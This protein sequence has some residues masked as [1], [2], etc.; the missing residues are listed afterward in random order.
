[1]ALTYRASSASGST[2][3]GDALT[4]T[5]PAGTVDGDILVAAFY[6]I[7]DTNTI[8]P[9]AGWTLIRKTINTAPSPTVQLV[10]FW[11]RAA[12]E[13][14]SWVFTPSDNGKNRFYVCVAYA[15]AT[16]SADQVDV[17]GGASG[18]GFAMTAPSVITTAA[19][20]TV[21]AIINNWLGDSPGYVSGLAATQ[22][23]QFVGLEIWEGTQ[24]LAAATGT[25]VYTTGTQDWNAQ[26]VAFKNDSGSSGAT[27]TGSVTL[28][29]TAL[30]G[31]LTET[32][33]ITGA[34]LLSA[35]SLAGLAAIYTETAAFRTVIVRARSLSLSAAARSLVVAPAAR[36]L[37]VEV[38]A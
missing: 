17:S 19:D 20:E 9:P 14:A 8:T 15:G 21:L 31:T 35:L 28:G 37:T 27:S 33:P 22:R 6:W 26:H 2:G 29:A 34:V 23:A 5:K 18:T 36:S 12:S 1:M 13:P 11:K 32:I 25:S 30:A 24:A 7:D 38:P 16:G 10:S 3:V 4:V